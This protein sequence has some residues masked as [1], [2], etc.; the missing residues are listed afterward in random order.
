M[1]IRDS[2]TSV[3]RS[4]LWAEQREGH[5]GDAV[6]T[7]VRLGTRR[8]DHRVEQV[9]AELVAEPAEMPHAVVINPPRELGLDPDRSVIVAR[10]DEVDLALAALCPEVRHRRLGRSTC[11]SS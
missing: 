1:C 8:D 4:R 10:D 3:R 9:I 5:D 2:L 11:A 6:G 7:T